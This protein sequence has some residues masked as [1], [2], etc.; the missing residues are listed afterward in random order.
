MKAFIKVALLV[1]CSFAVKP[2]FAQQKTGYVTLSG[3]LKGFSNQAEVED[4]SEYQYLLPPTT[5]RM[6]VPDVN[7]HFSIKFKAD[8]PNYYRLGRNALYLTP[9]DQLEVFIDKGNPRLATFNGS[10]AEANRY[11]KNTPFPKGGSFLEAGTQVKETPGATIAAVEELAA[12]RSKELEATT[13][14][15]TEFRRL[16]TARIKADLINSI[17]SGETYGIYK[18]KLKDTAAKAYTENYKKAIE[19][20]IAKY[21]KN[22]TDPSLMKLVV[23]RDIAEDVIKL[24][25]KPADI[26]VIKD[27]YTASALVKDMQKLSDKAQLKTFAAR[28]TAVKTASY[29]LAAKKMLDRLMAFGK[30]DLAA[31]F[32]ATDMSGNQVSLSSLKGKVV[33]VDLWATWCGPCMDEMPHFEALKAKYKDNPDVAFVSLS[34][35]DTDVPW[36]KSVE[37]RKVN[38]YQWLINR[39][40]LQAY[41]IV[42]IPRTLLIDKDFKIVDMDAPMPSQADAVT[43]IEALCRDK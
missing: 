23:Y 27:W 28:T 1:C 20:V 11:M 25:G 15:T 39:S 33:Y 40:K 12:Q 38:G 29:R 30:G 34:I 42:G 35:D 3:Q 4:M 37:S 18:L 7:G 6:I 10:G 19:P 9:G 16:E 17:Y 13:G 5:D 22:F 14:I 26:Q 24:G 21:G 36:K 2:A 31:D 8:A 43:A 32:V 41:N